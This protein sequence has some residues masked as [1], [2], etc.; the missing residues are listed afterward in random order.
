MCAIQASERTIAG[1]M[2]NANDIMANTLL[3]VA[4][5]A[6]VILAD[7]QYESAACGRTLLTAPSNAFAVLS[8][9]MTAC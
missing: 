1:E 2:L 7:A 5:D 9:D 4:T 3:H 6:D 8:D